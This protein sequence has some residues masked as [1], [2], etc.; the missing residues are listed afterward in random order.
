M[1]QQLFSLVTVIGLAC[2]LSACASAD[3]DASRQS[4]LPQP[5]PANSFAR[6]WA[7]DLKLDRG[8]AI[9]S[10][11]V[12]DDVLF[13]Y[14]NQH[15][16]YAIGRS[17]GGLQYA[18]EPD[19]SGGV[20]RPPLVLGE[21]VIYPSGSSLEVFNKQG[22]RV[23]TIELEKPTRGGAA[24]TGTSV[25][26]GLDHTG[27]TGVI[28][29]LDIT[30][31]YR[32]INWELMTFGAV[33]PTPALYEGVIYAGSEDGKIYAVTNDR[34]PAWSL[35][36]GSNT[37]DT[38]GRFIADI[39]VDD[40]GLYAANTDS[41]LYC[42]D[43]QSG[44]L[45]WIYYAGGSSLKTA[46]VAGPTL[47]YQFVPGTGVV[48]IDKQNGQY[49]RV[50]V[51][52]VKDAVAFLSEDEGYAYLQRKDNRILAIEKQTGKLTFISKRHPLR[53]FATNR[54]DSTIYGASKDGKVW[55][56]RPVLREGEVGRIVI[57]LRFEPVG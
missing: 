26:I 57:D 38:R 31:A 49:N 11:F 41:K 2:L 21:T 46:P 47:V 25:Y 8:D 3:K 53:V 52:T 39:Q 34:S 54:K 23:R 6:T 36:G 16:V 13:V 55:A 1:K 51:W 4:T 5:L 22:R 27:G 24:G 40:F 20:L 43:R 29:A 14:T 10:L 28:A 15:V 42:L 48:A 50:P 18:A 17:G 7:N 44:R 56:V 33:T 12:R 45:K 37:F 32:V 9:K 35:P 30:K 19:V